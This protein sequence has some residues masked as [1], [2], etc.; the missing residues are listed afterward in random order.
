MSIEPYQLMFNRWSQL[1]IPIDNRRIIEAEY[2][3][4]ED[5]FV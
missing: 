4:I 3:W 1:K 2:H 5:L